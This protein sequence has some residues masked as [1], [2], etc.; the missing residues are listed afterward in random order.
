MFYQK[1]HPRLSLFRALCAGVLLGLAG[2]AG[3]ASR[4][5][6]R[7]TTV[8]VDAGHGGHDSGAVAR[9]SYSTSRSRKG[10][11]AKPVLVSSV[12]AVEKELAVDVARRLK[13]RLT[14]EGLRVVMTRGDDTFIPLDERV[15]ISN[16]QRNSIFVSIHFNDSRKRHIHGA[17]VYH[18]GR[19]TEEFARRIVRSLAT[20][21]GV[22]NRG[23]KHAQFRVLRNSLGPAVL[24]ECGYLSNPAEAARCA[25][26]A[27]RQQLAEAISRAI[28]EQRR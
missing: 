2:C 10:R 24:I 16:R 26:P 1:I 21:P 12:R 19:G 13:S 3:P 22:A 27:H 17:E 6:T 14:E 8:V 15:A 5:V 11:K 7:F 28:M 9:P 4:E 20:V 23:T 25:T 18:N